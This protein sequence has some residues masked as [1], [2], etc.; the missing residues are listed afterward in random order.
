MIKI[1][2]FQFI[3]I[4]GQTVMLQMKVKITELTI[5]SG[6]VAGWPTLNQT[7]LNFRLHFTGGRSCPARRF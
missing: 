1:D 2:Y 3:Y 7:H 6:M 4:V 5:R